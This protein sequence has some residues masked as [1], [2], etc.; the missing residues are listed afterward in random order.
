MLNFFFWFFF[1]RFALD[2]DLDAPKI[3][4]P[5]RACDSSKCE[6]H[7]LFD[8]GN[9]TLRTK[10]SMLCGLTSPF[11]C[12]T[13]PKIIAFCRI[14]IWNSRGRTCTPAFIFLE[15][16]SQHALQSVV[17][18]VTVVHGF[19][20]LPAIIFLTLLWWRKLIISVLLLIIVVWQ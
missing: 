8:L 18:I 2:I 6:S 15:E 19:Y 12:L 3:R 7:L 20:H 10:V 9:F 14:A 5:I 16:I 11:V 4:V 17:L 13:L 1:F